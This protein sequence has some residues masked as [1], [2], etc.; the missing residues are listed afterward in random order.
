MGYRSLGSPCTFPP[1]WSALESANLL[2]LTCLWRTVEAMPL[3]CAGPSAFVVVTRRASKRT[4]EIIHLATHCFERFE[5]IKR[6][7]R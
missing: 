1:D 7:S 6:C 4:R 5:R 3:G 2:L